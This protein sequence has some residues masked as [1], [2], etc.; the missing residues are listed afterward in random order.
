MKNKLPNFLIVGAAK[1]G[2]TSLY[3]YLKEHKDIYLSDRKEGQFLSKMED[4]NGAHTDSYNKNICKSLKQYGSFFNDVK[5]E[6]RIGDISPDY[7]YFYKNTIKSIDIYLASKPKIII[8]L[9]NPIDRAFSQYTF[10]YQQ[11]L[12][13]FSFNDAIA[14]EEERKNENWRIGYRY[15]ELGLYYKQ[16]KNFQDKYDTLIID[17]DDLKT[18]RD[19]VLKQILIFLDLDTEIKL[20]DNSVHN[21]SGLP[22]NIFIYKILAFIRNNIIFRS[23]LKPF[24]QLLISKKTYQMMISKIFNI[25]NK[26]VKIDLKTR[27]KLKKYYHDDVS[28]LQKIVDFDVMKWVN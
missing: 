12:E 5:N 9:R 21:N 20:K 14:K 27:D 19:G 23:I 17:F 10:Y 24:M 28:M 18:N 15:L 16:V 2:T 25:T 4:F 6:T 13:E 1:A 7:L 3:Q 11:F 8:I 26:K 22:K